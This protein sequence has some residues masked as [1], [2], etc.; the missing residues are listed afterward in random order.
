MPHAV[1]LSFGFIRQVT[2]MGFVTGAVCLDVRKLY[3]TFDYSRALL[4]VPSSY[5]LV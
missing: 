3:D 1:T 2:E 5:L 4:T